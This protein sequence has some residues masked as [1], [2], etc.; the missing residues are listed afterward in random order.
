MHKTF[1]QHKQPLIDKIFFPFSNPVSNEIDN[2]SSDQES[3]CFQEYLLLFLAAVSWYWYYKSFDEQKQK[4]LWRCVVFV[5]DYE[6][7]A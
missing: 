7:L 3:F 6:K 5:C 1:Q 4:F 2:F